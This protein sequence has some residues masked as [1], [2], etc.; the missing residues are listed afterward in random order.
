MASEF[1]NFKAVEALSF[2]WKLQVAAK[3]K[4]YL[5]KKQVQHLA[6]ELWKSEDKMWYHLINSHPMM[7]Q[8]RLIL[9]LK[10]LRSTLFFTRKHTLTS[11]VPWPSSSPFLTPQTFSYS[12]PTSSPLSFLFFLNKTILLTLEKRIHFQL[13]KILL[14]MHKLLYSSCKTKQLS[15]MIFKNKEGNQLTQIYILKKQKSVLKSEGI[16]G[17]QNF[18]YND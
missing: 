11:V 4:S 13:L 16:I 6:V 2:H 9:L 8:K 7:A 5:L 14:A 12:L 3:G 1:K 15:L 17:I 10:K 18:Y